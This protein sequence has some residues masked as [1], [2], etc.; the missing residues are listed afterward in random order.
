MMRKGK[1]D[2][3]RGIKTIEHKFT[4]S[5]ERDEKDGKA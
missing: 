1:D 3:K 5:L 4:Y 2:Q